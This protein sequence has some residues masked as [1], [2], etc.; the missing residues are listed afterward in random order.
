M[1]RSLVDLTNKNKR[2]LDYDDETNTLENV[3]YHLIYD[4]HL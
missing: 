4:K 1:L 3:K 2:I